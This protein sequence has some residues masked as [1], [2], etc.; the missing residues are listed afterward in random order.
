VRSNFPGRQVAGVP[1]GEPRR[2]EVRRVT[3]TGLVV[4]RRWR[5]LLRRP[6]TARAR[7]EESSE[8]DRPRFNRIVRRALERHRRACLRTKMRDLAECSGSIL[9]PVWG[10]AI[11]I[12]EGPVLAIRID[13]AIRFWHLGLHWVVLDR[14]DSITRARL[15]LATLGSVTNV[16]ETDTVHSAPV[17]TGTGATVVRALATG[18]TD[19][20]ATGITAM[21]TTAMDGIAVVGMEA[22]IPS[23]G[24]EICLGWR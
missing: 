19:I 12:S 24:S 23:G 20:M 6:T 3:E 5:A 9:V 10:E 18:T 11:R 13:L 16:R 22:A 1:V 8:W 4:E 21:A 7:A 17:D 14:R 15:V 2:D